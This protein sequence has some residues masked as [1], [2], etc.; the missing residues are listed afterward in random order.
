ML[1]DSKFH[2]WISIP[3]SEARWQVSVVESV[4][5]E[6][7]VDSR[8]GRRRRKREH[9]DSG[10]E[11]MAWVRTF[12]ERRRSEFLWNS[13]H[14]SASKRRTCAGPTGN[15]T[16]WNTDSFAVRDY[17]SLTRIEKRFFPRSCP[18]VSSSRI[19]NNITMNRGKVSL[20][21]KHDI[22]EIRKR[23]PHRRDASLGALIHRSLSPLIWRCFRMISESSGS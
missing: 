2:N 4:Y 1:L 23:L 22:L 8:G 19:E 5:L 17:L 18:T 7:F 16:L 21:N 13:I 20:A 14:W 6:I 10:A 12:Q 15:A 11:R 9:A 3:D